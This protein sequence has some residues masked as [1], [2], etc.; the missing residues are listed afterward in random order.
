MEKLDLEAVTFWRLSGELYEAKYHV[1]NSFGYDEDGLMFLNITKV[2]WIRDETG[3]YPDY[4]IQSLTG[5][6]EFEYEENDIS[7]NFYEHEDHH[8]LV[9]K[10]TLEKNTTPCHS[11]IYFVGLSGFILETVA[12]HIEGI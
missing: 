1:D 2:Y 10:R 7:L 3:T 5:R 8:A 12:N 11:V 6:F 9:I 4:M